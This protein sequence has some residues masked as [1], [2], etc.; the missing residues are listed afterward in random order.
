MEKR[1]E[2]LGWLIVSNPK[3]KQQPHVTGVTV[4]VE[5]YLVIKTM[6]INET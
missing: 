1:L 4:K 5:E 6:Y 3:S 2:L